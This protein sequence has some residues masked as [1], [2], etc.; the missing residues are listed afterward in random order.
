MDRGTV[1]WVMEGDSKTG[2]YLQKAKADLDK[3][4]AHQPTLARAWFAVP[5]SYRSIRSWQPGWPCAFCLY[6]R[7]LELATGRVPARSTPV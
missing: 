5:F 2:E 4:I 3:A 1:Y 6:R 7:T